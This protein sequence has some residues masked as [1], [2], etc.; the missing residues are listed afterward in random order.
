MLSCL[1]QIKHNL[2]SLPHSPLEEEWFCPLS[3]VIL[4]LKILVRERL[5]TSNFI[6]YNPHNDKANY[7]LAGSD[8]RNE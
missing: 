2:K 1:K 5:K 4:Y 7:I 6:Y 8:S 3:N